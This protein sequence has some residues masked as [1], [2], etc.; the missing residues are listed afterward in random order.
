MAPEA[1]VAEEERLRAERE[2]RVL[3]FSG[4]DNTPTSTSSGPFP[5][6][7]PPPPPRFPVH[8]LVAHQ[9]R[10]PLSSS[11]RDDTTKHLNNRLLP[12]PP[13]TPTRWQRPRSPRA[14]PP[15]STSSSTRP[16]STPSFCRSRWIPSSRRPRLRPPPRPLLLLLLLLLEV[17]ARRAKRLA[18]AALLELFLPMLQRPPP[19]LTLPKSARGAPKAFRPRR[20]CSRSSRASSATTSCEVREGIHLQKRVQ[21]VEIGGS[22][23]EIVANNYSSLFRAFRSRPPLLHL[24]LGK[25]LEWFKSD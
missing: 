25:C 8:L 15:S 18:R 19:P 21:E 20:S 22:V 1:A 10:T 23:P 13:P 2:V 17:A 4:G 16:T 11:S 9:Q 12:P 14:A 7:S 6:L 5:F 24:L 3:F